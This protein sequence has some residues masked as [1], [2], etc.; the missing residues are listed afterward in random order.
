MCGI[1]GIL[2]NSAVAPRLVA[3]L[4]RLEYRGYDSAGV[5]TLEHGKLVRRRAAGKLANLEAELAASPLS[6]ISGIGHT[7]WATHGA[8]TTANAHP[9]ATVKVAIVHNGIIENFRALREQLMGAGHKFASETD[10]EVIAHLITDYLDK[11]HSPEQAAIAAVRRLEGA[12]GIACLFAGEE[13][14]LI[15]A[16]FSAHPMN[17]QFQ[18]ARIAVDKSHALSAGLPTEWRMTDEWYSFKTNPRLTGAKVVL[19]L[20][21]STYTREGRFGEPLD[22]GADHP[23]AWT[24][25]IGKGRMFYSAIG[26]LPETYRHPLHLTL[27]ENA[28]GWAGNRKAAC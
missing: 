20:D 1:I 15:G 11:G 5:A 19:T 24:R 14:V 16:R 22:M 27:L 12:F 17:P 9:H 7:R 26:H 13:D 8:P 2:G 3:S 10:S 25:C 4:K 28:I 18:E 23:L 6:G 21:E